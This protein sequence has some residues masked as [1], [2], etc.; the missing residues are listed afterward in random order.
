M[1]A[2][3]TVEARIRISAPQLGPDVEALVLS[4]LRSGH[5]A[6]GPMVERFEA[7]CAGMAGTS[8]AVAVGN[9]TVALDAALAVLDI[10]PGCVPLARGRGQPRRRELP[11]PGRVHRPRADRRRH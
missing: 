5:L 4:V 7:L 10:G 6:Q 3:Q 2:T 9:G 11:G 1:T 8:H